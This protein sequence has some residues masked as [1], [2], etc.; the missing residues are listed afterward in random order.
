MLQLGT[1]HKVRTLYE[2]LRSKMKKIWKSEEN[3]M[4]SF[5][6]IRIYKALYVKIL[7]ILFC[8]IFD[9]STSIENHWAY[10]RN[11]RSLNIYVR[12]ISIKYEWINERIYPREQCT[13]PP[14][15]LAIWDLSDESCVVT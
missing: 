9:F 6:H 7:S 13:T 8:R 5:L 3:E 1:V 11:E 14:E 15:A 12:E 2:S 10:V 4:T